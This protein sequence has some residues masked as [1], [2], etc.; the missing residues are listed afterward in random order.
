MFISLEQALH[1]LETYRYLLLFPIT[2][3]EGPIIT[4]IAGSLAALG[5]M[6][7]FIVWGVS[8][9]G[10]LVGDTIYYAIG[11]WGRY[12]FIERWGG[13]VGLRKDRIAR[14][15]AHFKQHGGKTLLFGK[16]SHFIGAPILVAAGMVKMPYA[17]YIWFC[18]VATLPKTLLLT[19]IGFY[20]GSAYLMINRYFTYVGAGMIMLG[21]ACIAVY[22]LAQRIAGKFAEIKE[23]E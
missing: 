7:F 2:V 3:V 5:Y 17:P 19:L 9:A 8:V 14:F 22:F 18:T 20:F 10:D 21:I 1:L 11:K 23:T 6:N 12:R 4:M 13:Y 16:F 15:E